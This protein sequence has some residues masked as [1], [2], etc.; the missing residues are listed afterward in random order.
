M[1]K[2]S[3]KVPEES[4]PARDYK[5]T[6]KITYQSIFCRTRH[7]PITYGR[8]KIRGMKKSWCQNWKKG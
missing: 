6:G 7:H 4:K 2:L 5:K 8:I 3:F 1:L